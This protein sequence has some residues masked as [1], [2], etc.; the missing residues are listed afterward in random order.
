MTWRVR[1]YDTPSLGLFLELEHVITQMDGHI[2]LRKFLIVNSQF[3]HELSF[4]RISVDSLIE[5]GQ[6]VWN[7]ISR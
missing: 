3:R 5:T 4:E 1:I 2:E 7:N 6:T